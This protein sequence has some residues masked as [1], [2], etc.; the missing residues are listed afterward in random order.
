MK[1]DFSRFTFDPSKHYSSTRMQQGR[2]QVDA[3]WNEQMD[4]FNY[5]VQTETNDFIGG[6]G[7]P[8]ANPTSFKISRN[9]NNNLMIGAGHYYVNGLLCENNSEIPFTQQL[10]YPDA[11]LPTKSGY[12][13]AYLDVWQWQVT[14]IEDPRIREVALGGADTTTRVRNL[15]QVKLFYAGKTAPSDYNAIV[16]MPQWQT[17]IAPSRGT[18]TAQLVNASQLGNQLYRVEI[19]QGGDQ[20]T[21]TFKWSRE[22]G[23]VVAGVQKVTVDSATDQGTIF[24]DQ[25]QSALPNPFAIGEWIELSNNL[26]TLQGQPSYLLQIIA[27]PNSNQLQVNWPQK[28]DPIPFT[29]DNLATVRLWNGDYTKNANGFPL[30]FG[31]LISLENGLEIQF[32]TGKNATFRTAD[33]WLIPARAITNSIDWPTDD[34]GTPLAITPQGIYHYYA[35]LALCQL[36]SGS[37]K[38]PSDWRTLFSPITSFKVLDAVEADPAAPKGSVYI[39]NQGNVGIG[40]HTPISKLEVNGTLTI[41]ATTGADDTSRSDMESSASGTHITKNTEMSALRVEGIAKVDT[42]TI[43]NTSS[44]SFSAVSAE[45]KIPVAD[46]FGRIDPNWLGNY[47]LPTGIV[48]P[49]PT[50]RFSLAAVALNGKIYTLGGDTGSSNPNLGVVEVFDPM[51]NQWYSVAPMTTPRSDLAAAVLNGRIYAIGGTSAKGTSPTV[52]IYDPI[53]DQWSPGAPMTTARRRLATVVLGGM[54]YAIGGDGG[55]SNYLA[56]AEVYDPTKQSWSL[57][58]KHM[59]EGLS[60]VVAAVVNQKIYAIGTDSNQYSRLEIYDPTNKSWTLGPPLPNPESIIVSGSMVNGKIHLFLFTI[61]DDKFKVAIYDPLAGAWH[62]SNFPSPTTARMLAPAVSTD[63]INGKIYLFG[64]LD[65]DGNLLNTVDVY[66][67]RRIG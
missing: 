26:L 20:T 16:N 14:A 12:Y 55:T 52:E 54:I 36:A 22:N 21:A 5:R 30:A 41:T 58:D 27:M 48:T 61:I 18:L 13:L 64:G 11:A 45:N 31:N 7:T 34:K 8:H 60:Y 37:W 1:G 50:T 42:L 47:W 67:P 33:Y 46:N 43:V 29:R 63:V 19:H 3:D 9:D 59:S 23:S 38:N 35:P 28:L 24:L 4:I 32:G 10:D 15:A 62:T 57:L 44:G 66:L 39:D 6:S 40:T 2:V 51:A 17:L 25:L 49:L 53:T 65:S 56:T